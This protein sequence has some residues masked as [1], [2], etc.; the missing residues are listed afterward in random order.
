MKKTPQISIIIP[1]YQAEKFIIACLNSIIWQTYTDYEI[2]L[3][4]DGSTDRSICLACEVLNGTSIDY[5]VIC[6][7]N[8]GAAAA[9]NRG[10]REAKGEFITFIDADDTIEQRHLENLLRGMQE[11]GSDVS[12]GNYRY[13]IGKMQNTTKGKYEKFRIMSRETVLNNFLVR[14]INI[15]V[16]AVLI[17]K[18]AFI[19]NDLW[20]EKSVRFGEDAIFYW[21]MLL[22]FPRIVY[23]DEPT[24]N[25]F[26]HPGSTTTAPS[27]DRMMSNYRAFLALEDYI[28][29]RTSRKFARYVIARQIFSMLRISAVYMNYQEFIDMY[30]SL[31][32]EEY[33]KILR[34]FPDSRVRCLCKSMKISK[35]I[36]YYMNKM[37][38][39]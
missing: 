11:G 26:I 38:G 27:K 3:I 7:V 12:I 14:R 16:T 23:I 22:A 28:A 8:S 4:D 1:V 30:N 25:Y 24:Y 19:N 31:G 18:E 39:Q 6:Q 20:F 17:R 34:E 15:V 21:K 9:R 5:R 37:R 29:T 10:V 2:I 32:F 33:R 36:F 35:R 13:I